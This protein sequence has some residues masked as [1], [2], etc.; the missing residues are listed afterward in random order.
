[1]GWWLVTARKAGG[2]AAA[3]KAAGWAHAQNG[4]EGLF[5]GRLVGMLQQIG[6]LGGLMPTRLAAE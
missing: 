3:E 1:M 6:Q 4:G 5:P 2:K